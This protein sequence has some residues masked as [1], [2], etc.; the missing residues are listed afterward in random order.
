MIEK[1]N[2][3]YARIYVRMHARIQLI[4]LGVGNNRNRKISLYSLA[5]E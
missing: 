3:E 1:E 4:P 2:V 5:L